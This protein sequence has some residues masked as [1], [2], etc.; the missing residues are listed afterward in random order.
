MIASVSIAARDSLRVSTVPSASEAEVGRGAHG[1]GVAH[2]HQM[3]AAPLDSACAGAPAPRPRRSHAASAR[4]LGHA[5]RLGEAK[6]IASTMRSC[7]AIGGASNRLGSRRRSGHA[8][9]RPPLA[10]L[11]RR[12]GARTGASRACAL[13]APVPARREGRG[14]GR[15]APHR[16]GAQP[17]AGSRRQIRPVARPSRSARSRSSASSIVKTRS[18]SITKGRNSSRVR[19]RA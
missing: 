6:R 17:R 13:L 11:D 16:I 14:G 19:M 12:E 5:H 1:P 4:Q 18:R 9:R 8:T 10:Q 3:H 2:P 15:A 7:S